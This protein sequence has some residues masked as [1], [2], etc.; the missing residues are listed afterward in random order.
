MDI[1]SAQ[2]LQCM[3]TLYNIVYCTLHSTRG[4]NGD[5]LYQDVC[6]DGRDEDIVMH[7]IELT[8]QGRIQTGVL[9]V[10][11]AG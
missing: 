1:Y 9:Y 10:V 3:C 2:H 7:T 5:G 11:G 6:R 8:V 4:S